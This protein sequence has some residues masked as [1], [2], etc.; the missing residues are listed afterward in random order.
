MLKIVQVG[1]G[2]L[3][4]LRIAG[5]SETPWVAIFISML[6]FLVMD[7]YCFVYKSSKMADEELNAIL[8]T[9]DEQSA[10]LAVLVLIYR[11][12]RKNH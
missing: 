3:W 7:A 11:Q 2:V 12:V 5:I 9:K 6:L 4:A 1:L 10:I 8:K